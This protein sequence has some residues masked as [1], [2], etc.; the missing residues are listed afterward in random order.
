MGK[1]AKSKRKGESKVKIMVVPWRD[2]E[3]F[4]QVHAGVFSEDLEPKQRALAKMTTWQ[5]RALNKLPIAIESTMALCRACI[6]HQLA[7]Q[8]GTV[9]ENHLKL[10]YEYSM[11][12]IRFVN[13][14]TELGQTGRVR[15]AVHTIAGNFGIPNWIVEMRHSATH[16]SMPSLSE[17]TAGTDWVLDWLKEDFWD[18]QLKIMESIKPKKSF[19]LEEDR[20]FVDKIIEKYMADTLKAI[21]TGEKSVNCYSDLLRLLERHKSRMLC[22]IFKKGHFIP[23]PVQLRELNISARELMSSQHLRIPDILGKLW[24]PLLNILHRMKLTSALVQLMVTMV[25]DKENFQ[26]FFLCSWLHRIISSNSMSGNYE[27]R[28]LKASKRKLYKYRRHIPYR[29]ILEKLLRHPSIYTQVII[30]LLLPLQTPAVTP[31]TKKKIHKLLDVVCGKSTQSDS[32][33]NDTPIHSI[34]D[35]DKSVIGSESEESLPQV[36]DIQHQAQQFNQSPWTRDQDILNWERIPLGSLDMFQGQITP[37]SCDE[38]LD[39]NPDEEDFLY[40]DELGSDPYGVKLQHIETSNDEKNGLQNKTKI[41][42]TDEEIN[43]I[44]Q[45]MDLI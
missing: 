4:R 29:L 27:E 11:G 24:G 37:I 9:H 26:N 13:N 16:R 45:T 22:C 25:T 32:S 39:E 28:N 8:E 20:E 33:E 38:S 18:A 12:I 30:K 15:M 6:S 42:W 36:G 40:E 3:E 44:K 43:I 31:A 10:V 34:L 2:K 35:V 5:S 21:R 41:L 7:I 23:T 14:I 19:D 1:A 17:L